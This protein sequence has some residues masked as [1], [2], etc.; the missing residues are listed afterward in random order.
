MALITGIPDININW[1]DYIENIERAA[2]AAKNAVA[3]GAGA[4]KEPE[5]QV[6]ISAALKDYMQAVEEKKTCESPGQLESLE[7]VIGTALHTLGMASLEELKKERSKIDATLEDLNE[8]QKKY[9]VAQKTRYEACK[10]EWM[11]NNPGKIFKY[12]FLRQED[13]KYIEDAKDQVS[14]FQMEYCAYYDETEVARQVLCEMILEKDPADLD[15]GS[16][17]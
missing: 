11:K 2:E 5:I 3:I 12:H 13:R 4:G 8:C 9:Y 1:A 17:W 7:F 6:D 15:L 16:G 10:A 14:L